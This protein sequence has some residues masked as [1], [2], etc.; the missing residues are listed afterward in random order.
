MFSWDHKKRFRIYERRAG[1]DSKGPWSGLSE[2]GFAY[3]NFSTLVEGLDYIRRVL[4]SHYSGHY[5]IV[6]TY[7]TTQSASVPR[8]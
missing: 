5:G 4:D 2:V 6:D 7:E 8:R 3:P 1:I